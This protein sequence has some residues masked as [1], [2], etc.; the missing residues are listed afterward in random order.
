MIF[1]VSQI[2]STQLQKRLWY[3]TLNSIKYLYLVLVQDVYLSEK[4]GI[5]PN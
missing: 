2:T 5:K 4:K 3:H 1:E